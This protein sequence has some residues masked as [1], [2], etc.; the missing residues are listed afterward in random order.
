VADVPSGPSC[1]PPTTNRIKKWYTWMGLGNCPAFPE[2][3]D[4][5]SY[6]VSCLIDIVG[7]FWWSFCLN[8][9][10]VL[11][12]SNVEDLMMSWWNLAL[13]HQGTSPPR[14]PELACSLPPVR[15][16]VNTARHIVHVFRQHPAPAV[17]RVS[18]Y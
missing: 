9:A 10:V 12:P 2:L 18:T 3:E 16:S 11:V 17:R 1:T 4:S 5:T 6:G 13:V 15:G 7:L 8:F 14:W